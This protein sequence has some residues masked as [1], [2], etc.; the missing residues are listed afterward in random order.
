MSGGTSHSAIYR[1]VRRALDGRPF[2]GTLVDV[3]CGRARIQDELR[4]LF[5]R[6]VGLDIMAFPGTAA[7]VPRVFADLERPLPVWD[8][9]ADV[10]IAV[11]TIE[12]LENPRAFVRE[13]A[14]ITRPGGLVL[15]TTPNQLSALSLLCL[16]LKRRFAAFQ[17][18][19]YP[20]HRTALL[21]IDL[22]RIT[23]EAGL[24]NPEVYFS[25]HGR[26]P[27]TAHAYPRWLARRSPS[28][29]SDNVLIVARKPASSPE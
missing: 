4:G 8:N 27:L 25:E 3:G 15:M 7:H 13:L 23:G 10:V 9:V 14:R 26:I 18:V 16:L 29:L 22:R 12:H 5:G 11:E 19:H 21:E 6:Y 24:V 1:M 20:A 28:Y 17:D 2:A